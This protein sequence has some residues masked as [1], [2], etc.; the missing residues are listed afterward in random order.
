MS[1]NNTQ[2]AARQRRRSRQKHLVEAGPTGGRSC[3]HVQAARQQRLWQGPGGLEAEAAK[4]RQDFGDVS[5][6]GFGGG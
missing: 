3:V 1:K 4:A 5:K 6:P 2:K